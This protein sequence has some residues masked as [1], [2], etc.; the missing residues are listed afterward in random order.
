MNRLLLILVFSVAVPL[1]NFS[2]EKNVFHDDILFVQYLID[3]HQYEDAIYILKKRLAVGSY[4]DT[5]SDSIYYYL[6]WSYYS[7]KSLDSSSASFGK[8]SRGSAFYLK[9][10]YFQASDNI[11]LNRT[12]EAKQIINNIDNG[13]DTLLYKLKGFELAGIALLE[14]N[15]Q[16]FQ[17]Q[18][19]EF[20]YDYF[21]L[22]EEEKNMGEYSKILFKKRKKS[23]LLAGMMSAVIPGSGKMYAGYRGQGISAF[24]LI[25]MLGGVV[26]ESYIKDG[27][28]SPQFIA[29]GSLFTLFYVGNILGSTL[30]VKIKR[31]E[32]HNEV[33]HNVL[34]DLHIPLRRIFD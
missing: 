7:L 29:F 9:S 17:R 1:E 34:F 23:P 12:S 27:Y 20:C 6:G 26:A 30:S 5:Q 31:N 13:N 10:K 2:Q 4:S 18:S 8:V 32:I 19:S 15:L 33:V 22:A 16:E 3:N 21:P 11:F 24:F 14:H 28:K 25:G